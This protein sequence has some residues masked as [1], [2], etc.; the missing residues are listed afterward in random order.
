MISSLAPLR[1]RDLR[2]TILALQGIK[3]SR[4]GA[5]PLWP[6]PAPRQWVWSL[7]CLS[8]RLMS[9]WSCLLKCWWIVMRS[10]LTAVAKRMPWNLRRF[11]SSWRSMEW[12]RRAA[13][14]T[15]P[16]L[17][18]LVVSL[19]GARIVRMERI[20]ISPLFALPRDSSDINSLITKD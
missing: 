8:R 19:I 7:T 4:N 5:M 14:I 9:R 3:I 10:K 15:M 20:L 13:I 12:P 1:L 18:C 6:L 16:I 2:G 17:R 11:L